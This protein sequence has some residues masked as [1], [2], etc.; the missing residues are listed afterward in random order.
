MKDDND[1]TY[2]LKRLRK[3][4]SPPTIEKVGGGRLATTIT[5]VE[6]AEA[7]K[8]LDCIVV[9]LEDSHTIIKPGK[10]GVGDSGMNAL[11]DK[12]KDTTSPSV[13]PRPEASHTIKEK[14]SSE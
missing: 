10:A 4:L 8:E 2:R 13:P 9:A 11:S 12:A 5:T 14:K 7:R 1:I 3:I 6:L